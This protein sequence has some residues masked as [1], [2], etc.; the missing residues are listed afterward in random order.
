[1]KGVLWRFCGAAT[2][3]I[4]IALVGALTPGS[5]AMANS[6]NSTRAAGAGSGT[7]V[8]AR[9]DAGLTETTGCTLTHQGTVCNSMF[10]SGSRVETVQAYYAVYPAV[11]I[12]DVRFRMT[13]TLANGGAYA[14]LGS[15]GCG[16]GAVWVIF[17]VNRS[18]QPGSK[19]CVSAYVDGAWRN[20]WAC[21]TIPR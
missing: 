11:V 14:R 12:C 2:A 15:A 13:G 21:V 6:H 17:T 10:H 1:M 8:S 18:F 20:Q 16:V 19:L 3:V 7:A 5:P 4:I 9:V